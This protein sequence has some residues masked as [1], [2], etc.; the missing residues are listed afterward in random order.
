MKQ[1][2]EVVKNKKQD[3]PTLIL[4]P[5]MTLRSKKLCWSV[6][7]VQKKSSPQ[8]MESDLLP[9]LTELF[10]LDPERLCSP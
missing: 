4:L 5:E 10:I 3:L 8:K 1:K 9:S 6:I 2:R 7:K